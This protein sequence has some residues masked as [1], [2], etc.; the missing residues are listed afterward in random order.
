MKKI[1]GYLLIIFPFYVILLLLFY[2]TKFFEDF[3]ALSIAM[4]LNIIFFIGLVLKD[5]DNFN[6]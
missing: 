6:L 1:I 5:F 4:L 2:N 3:I